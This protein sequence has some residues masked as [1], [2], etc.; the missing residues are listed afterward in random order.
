M[1]AVV[2]K[3]GRFRL[4][5]QAPLL[6]ECFQHRGRLRPERAVALL[7]PFSKQPRLKR[8][9][10]LEIA[11]AQICDLLDAATGVEHSCQQSVVAAS[12]YC[13]PVDGLE[14]RIDLLIF[15]VVNSSL[16]GAL[17][18]NAEDALGQFEMLW[19]TRGYKMKKRMNGRKSHVSR[20]HTVLAFL[21]KVGQEREDTGR[22]QIRQIEPRNRLI[23][24][25]G[26]K[27][28]Q[29]NDAVAVAVD[30]VWAGS[31]KAGQMIREVVPDYSAEKIGKLGFHPRLRRAEAGGEISAP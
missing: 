5:V 25:S 28:Q 14:N 29:Q 17:E 22:V 20:G 7:S 31:T 10:Q 2:Q 1:A 27:P 11:H 3:E 12:L 21:F 24:L 9:G 30:G 16:S 15:Q 8:P 13:G 6:T 18:G 26:E 19:V 4:Q 23:P